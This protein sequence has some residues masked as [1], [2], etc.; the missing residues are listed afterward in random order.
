MKRLGDLCVVCCMFMVLF[1]P[2]NSYVV[3][4]GAVSSAFMSIDEGMRTESTSGLGRLI[5]EAVLDSG[6]IP[7]LE[8]VDLNNETSSRFHAERSL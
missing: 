7:S 2:V 6:Y 8:R 3:E 4:L 1:T 5:L